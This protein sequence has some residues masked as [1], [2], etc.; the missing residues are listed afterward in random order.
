MRPSILPAILMKKDGIQETVL[1][2]GTVLQV[3][4]D[5]VTVS[6][7]AVS[8]CSGCHA[9][10]FCNVSGKEEKLIRIPGNYNVNRGDP[11][12]VVMNLSSGYKAL[13][14]SYIVPLLSVII[15]LVILTSLEVPELTAGLL[16]VALLAPWYLLLYLLRSR[17]DRSFTFSLK[18]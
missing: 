16:S 12:T 8:A 6:I 15:S 11:V 4:G 14:L 13:I 18:V 2:E 9:E 10:S 17:I 3:A 1:H 5:S 7:T